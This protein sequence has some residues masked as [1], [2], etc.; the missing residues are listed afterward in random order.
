MY[1]YWL[2]RWHWPVEPSIV[3][4]MFDDI[5]PLSLVFVNDR[6]DDTDLLRRVLLIIVL[7]TLICGALYCYWYVWWHQSIEP[8][9][10]NDRVDDTDPLSRVLLIIGLMTL[11]CW[12]LYCY[13]YVW[14]HQSIEP[15]I[16]SLMIG[17]MTLIHWAVY[18]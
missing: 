5:N 8:C 16:H 4:D 12:A 15:C 10:V 6:V 7:M 14:W 11:I 17:L 18:C 13:W 2:V 3:I 9:I 1:R